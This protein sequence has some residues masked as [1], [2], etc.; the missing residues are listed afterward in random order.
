M[1]RLTSLVPA[2]F[3]VLTLAAYGGEKP[4]N[5][6]CYTYLTGPYALLGQCIRDGVVM[7]VDQVNAAGGIG[8]RPVNLTV[9][10]DKGSPETDVQVVTRLVD[11]DKCVAIVA[12]ALSSA[13]MATLP[14][15]EEAQI[16]QVSGGV[17]TSFTNAGYEYTFRSTGSGALV[18]AGLIDVMQK[19]GVKKLATVVVANEYGEN[20][21]ETIKNLLAETNIELTAEEYFQVGDTDFTVQ[22]HNAFAT[23]PD[24]LLLYSNTTEQAQSMKQLGRMDFEG[25]VIG[26]EGCSSPDLLNVAGA[27]ANDLIFVASYVI[28]HS[29]AEATNPK[30]QEFLE[31]FVA[32]YGQMPISDTVYRAYDGCQLLFEAMRTCD[33]VDAPASIRE[34]F[35]K[36]KGF[37]GIGGTFDY[38]DESGDGL[39]VARAYKIVDG[40]YVMLEE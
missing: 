10:D 25:Y 7:A 20:G 8:G 3:L 11:V 5:L 30:E 1:K 16:V 40:R 33:D 27:D 34:A 28:P 4:I 2:L 21:I 19:L 32:R 36:I 35:V 14:I 39:F 12:P 17:S 29:P 15:T 18:N 31:A 22:F 38:T 24:A 23:E 26:T 6:G 13:I 37:E 9:Y